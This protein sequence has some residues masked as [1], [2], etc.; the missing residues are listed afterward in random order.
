VIKI[1]KYGIF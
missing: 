1:S